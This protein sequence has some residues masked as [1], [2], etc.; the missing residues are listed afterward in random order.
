MSIPVA[1][2]LVGCGDAANGGCHAKNGTSYGTG[3]KIFIVGD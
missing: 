1:S 3:G 2:P